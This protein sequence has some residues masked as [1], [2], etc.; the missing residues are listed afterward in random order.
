[1]WEELRQRLGGEF[2]YGPGHWFCVPHEVVRR[3]DGRPFS[4]KSGGSGRRVVLATRHGP[5]ATLFARST[6]VEGPFSHLA[7]VHSGG[8]GR[9]RLDQNGWIN[10]RIPVNVPSSIL[11]DE[12]YSCEEPTAG[13]L[14]PAL[15]RAVAL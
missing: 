4:Y 1:V 3:P 11:C 2:L 14:L 15:E 7:H 5:N 6:S 8:A 9:C 10:L 13:G 12:T